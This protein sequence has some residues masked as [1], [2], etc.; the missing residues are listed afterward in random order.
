MNDIVKVCWKSP[1]NIAFVKYWGKYGEQLPC[2]A[3]L[4]MTLSECFTTTDVEL[5]PKKTK[6]EVELDFYFAGNKNQAF[7][8]RIHSYLLRINSLFP[9]L[10]E[11]RIV[12]N[13]ENSFPHSAGIAS[14]ASA[15]SALALSLQTI[16]HDLEKVELS[17]EEH[18][19]QASDLARLGS[20]SAARSV[21]GGYT[22]WGQTDDCSGSSDIH[23]IKRNDELDSQFAALHDTI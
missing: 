23:A 19:R 16:K 8:K 1:S 10:K 22:V 9:F 11:Y 14:S 7:Q 21:F 3:S 13:T 18:Y 4:S 20:G 5:Q 17:K 6:E 15:F 2:N 12:I